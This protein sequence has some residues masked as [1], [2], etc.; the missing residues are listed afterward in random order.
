M[1]ADKDFRE[2]NLDHPWIVISGLYSSF[3]LVH[4]IRQS[5]LVFFCVEMKKKAT[6]WLGLGQGRS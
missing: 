3:E 1:E 4:T 5:L 2:K 6:T